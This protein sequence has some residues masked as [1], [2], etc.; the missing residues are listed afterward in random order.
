MSSRHRMPASRGKEPVENVEQP[1][2]DTAAAEVADTAPADTA[3]ADAAPADA[4]VADAETT[5]A[6]VTDTESLCHR[7]INGICRGVGGI[8]RRA[9]SRKEEDQLG[10]VFAFGVLPAIALLLALAAGY[11]RWE[12]N[13]SEYGA[14]PP[15]ASEQNPSPAFDSVNAAKDSTIKMLSY[16]PD[17]VEQQLNAAR[18]LLTGEFKDSY[19]SLINDVVIPG[20]PR[21]RFRPSRRFRPLRRCRPT[22]PTP[23]CW[24]L[25]TKRWSSARSF[26]PTRHP[27]C[28]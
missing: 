2:E 16:K 7:G 26:R 28:G 18:D 10:R 3:P 14:V 21:S 8:C 24:S 23:W 17:T 1:T 9:H 5:D 6:E 4:E 12:L 11:A 20:R 22:R 15:A 27:A 13:T 19:T 25:S